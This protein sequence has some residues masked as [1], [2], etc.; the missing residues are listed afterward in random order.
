MGVFEGC[1]GEMRVFRVVFLWCSCGGMRGKRGAVTVCFWVLKTCRG[2]QLYFFSR[3][4]GNLTLQHACDLC[5]HI[6]SM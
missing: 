3:A 4:I 6:T 1:F 2:F 5:C